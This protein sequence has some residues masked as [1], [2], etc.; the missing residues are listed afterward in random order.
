MSAGHTLS[1]VAWWITFSKQPAWIQKRAKSKHDSLR[2]KKSENHF[3]NNVL[4]SLLNYSFFFNT[5]YAIPDVPFSISVK[6]K[7][8]QLSTLVNEVL[9]GTGHSSLCATK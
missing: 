9:R 1:A 7:V 5:R 6:I 2:N 3:T 4:I 8:D